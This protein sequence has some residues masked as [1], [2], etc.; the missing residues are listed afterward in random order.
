MIKSILHISDTHGMHRRL[1][2][3]LAADAPMMLSRR[4]SSAFE[5]AHFEIEPPQ[6]KRYWGT[7]YKPC[8]NRS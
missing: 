5:A 4:V 6:M 2:N 3:L 7:V 8:F 1:T